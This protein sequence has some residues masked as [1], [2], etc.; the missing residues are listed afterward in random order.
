M[1]RYYLVKNVDSRPQILEPGLRIVSF[2]NQIPIFRNTESEGPF[3]TVEEIVL[4]SQFYLEHKKENAERAK[5]IILKKNILNADKPVQV[6]NSDIEKFDSSF[7]DLLHHILLGNIK[8]NKLQ[9]IHFFDRDL[10]EVIIITKSIDRFG[11]WEG[12]VR[13]KSLKKNNIK[14]KRSTFFPE[15]WNTIILVQK[16][17]EA[18]KSKI[19]LSENKYRG[20][21]KEGMYI[22]FFMDK[23][24]LLTV[25]PECEKRLL[26]K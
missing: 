19:K 7:G 15:N 26:P 21:T 9:G 16:L 14:D 13:S 3:Y 1:I 8:K 18:F 24:K 5:Q 20:Q 25:Y 22:I 17:I 11:V 10:H 23:N 2:K 12:I 4:N 6:K